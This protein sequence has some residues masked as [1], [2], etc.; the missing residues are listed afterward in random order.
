MGILFVDN[1]PGEANAV[2]AELLLPSA[3]IAD[4]DGRRL[5]TEFLRAGGGRGEITITRTIERIDVHRGGTIT[6]FS[7]A[8]PTAFGHRLKP[9]ISAPGG[10][11]LSSTLPQAGGP[12]AVFDGT[13]MAAP[14]VTGAAALLLQRHPTWTAQQVKSALVSSARA[15]WEDTAEQHEAPV[16][17]AGGGLVSV[18]RADNPRIFTTP[19]SLSFGDVDARAGA[20]HRGDARA[21][22]GRRRG[23]RHVVAGGASAGCDRRRHRRDACDARP[24]PPA[25]TRSSLSRCV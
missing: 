19:A 2:P 6:S 24:C 4:E 7:S 14:H 16:T 13:S 11:I 3:T 23:R 21:D 10:Q 18:L 22:P 12:F 17:L 15:A 20:A 25:A 5:R 8:G 1:R 9:D